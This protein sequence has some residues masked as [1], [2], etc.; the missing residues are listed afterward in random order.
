M[1]VDT[2]AVLS[3][4]FREPGH[5]RLVDVLLRANGAAMSAPN[6]AEAGIV[7]AAR[8]GPKAAGLLDRMATEFR[9]EVVPFTAAHA[10]AATEAFRRYGKGRHAAGLNF[11]KCM[12][13][14]TAKLAQAPLLFAGDDFEQT[15]IEAAP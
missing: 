11:G 4:V 3:I 9:I 15:D 10:L 2:S 12:A 7:L 6:A 13:Y 14:A 1:I 8:L 5:E